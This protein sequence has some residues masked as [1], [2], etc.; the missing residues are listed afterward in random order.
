MFEI[1]LLQGQGVPIKSSPKSIAVATIAF[2]IPVIVSIVMFSAYLKNN[3]SMS[4]QKNQIANYEVKIEQLSD[5]LQMQKSFEQE[6]E[7]IKTSLDEAKSVL[8]RHTQWSPILVELVKNMPDSVILSKLEVKQHFTKRKVPK[9]DDPQ[10][11]VD[12]SVPI[13]TLRITL[14]ADPQTNSDQAV[15]NFRNN[16]LAS[17]VIGPKLEDLR[18]SQEVENFLGKEVVSYEIDCILKPQL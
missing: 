16:L 4:I 13:R 18:I 12:I 8:T 2:A 11:T 3:I 1:D 9:K 5:A 10:K 15:K 14:N 6:K 7:A 17:A